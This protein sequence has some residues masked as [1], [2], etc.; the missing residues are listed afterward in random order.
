MARPFS[1]ASFL[2]V[3]ALAGEAMAVPAGPLHGFTDE[4]SAAL[5]KGKSVRRP[6]ED[7]A[8]LVG[9][10]SWLVI[11]APPAEVWRAL[12]DLQ[13]YK[14]MFRFVDRIDVLHADGR[15]RTVQIE[16]ADTLYTLSYILNL[17]FDE[18]NQ[19]IEFHLDPSTREHLRDGWGFVHLDATPSGTTLVTFG[20]AVN[21]GNDMIRSL[22]QE[23]LEDQL[24]GAPERLKRYI[25]RE[26][27]RRML[28]R[29]QARRASRRGFPRIATN[30][31]AER[32]AALR[33]QAEAQSARTTPAVV[34]TDP[35]ATPPEPVREPE[36]SLAPDSDCAR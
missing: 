26:E 14:R 4:E 22:F 24:L 27:R 13:T 7:H 19:D 8:R 12:Q 34:P 25:E 3:F 36:F 35:P 15:R 11:E 29:N 10:N 23:G 32:A 21:P 33:A 17:Q 30:R 16:E 6:L 9:G 1:L 2:A 28:A 20:A 18:E 5:R 31:Y